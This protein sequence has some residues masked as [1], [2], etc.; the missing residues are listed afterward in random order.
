MIWPR[1]SRFHLR[2]SEDSR[3]RPLTESAMIGNMRLTA[4]K[5]NDSPIVFNAI[6]N[7]YLD[8]EGSYSASAGTVHNYP[9]EI[10]LTT[11]G[12]ATFKHLLPEHSDYPLPRVIEGRIEGNKIHI[13]TWKNVNIGT[14]AG[15]DESAEARGA[16]VDGEYF[17]RRVIAADAYV[18]C[19]GGDCYSFVAG[20]ADACGDC[21]LT[22]IWR[23]GARSIAARGDRRATRGRRR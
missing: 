11:G 22:G 15:Y 19:L 1:D 23:R 17:S 18:A 6:V 7:S 2:Q 12:K 9:V 5:Y 3:R 13:P 10:T 4:G 14:L 8:D 21:G 16:A 20:G